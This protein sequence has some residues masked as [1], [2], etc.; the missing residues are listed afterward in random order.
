V[1]RPYPVAPQHLPEV[2]H[3]IAVLEADGII[4]RSQS[5]Y[6]PPALFA[7]KKDGRLC[8][9]IHYRKLDCQTLWDCYPTPVATDL[10]ARSGARM[11]SK[12]DLD[13][14]F[15]LLR[16]R[17]GDQHKTAFVTPD[18]QYKWVTCPYGLPTHPTTSN[19]S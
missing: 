13:S 1:G 16:I 9:C 3:Q 4:R 12:L 19:V 15:H 18:G 14:G 11:F 2:N 6:A 7:P 17:K 5:L 8:L 10:I